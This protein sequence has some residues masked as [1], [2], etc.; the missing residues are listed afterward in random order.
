M[1]E[2]SGA[3]AAG[4][5]LV[6]TDAFRGTDD[7]GLRTDVLA[8]LLEH[9]ADD[10]TGD[11]GRTRLSLLRTLAVDQTDRDLLFEIGADVNQ[12]TA[13]RQAVTRFFLAHGTPTV[14]RTV[15]SSSAEGNGAV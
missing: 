3:A 7:L 6:S 13:I 15:R 2:P 11:T 14:D 8:A 1:A 4:H 12:P 10:A 5:L 9:W